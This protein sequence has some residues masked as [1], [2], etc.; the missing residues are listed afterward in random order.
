MMGD[1]QKSVLLMKK[2]LQENTCAGVFVSM[3]L[4]AASIFIEK[5]LHHRCFIVIFT[6]IFAKFDTFLCK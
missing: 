2:T 5:R 4:Q 3:Q 1:N 6:K